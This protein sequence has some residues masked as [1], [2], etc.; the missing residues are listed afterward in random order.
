M[1]L[2]A[3]EWDDEM[4]EKS[5]KGEDLDFS[6]QYE[7]ERFVEQFTM[8]AAKDILCAIIKVQGTDEMGVSHQEQIDT[9]IEYATSLVGALKD[10]G[11][12]DILL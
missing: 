3:G 1:P 5:Y 8:N 4:N 11:E 6:P 12:L 9:A 2:E 7:N 10:A